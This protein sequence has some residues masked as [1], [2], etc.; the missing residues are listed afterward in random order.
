MFEIFQYDFMLRAFAAGLMIGVLAPAIGVFLVVKRYSLL[1]DTLAHVSLVGVAVSGF[2]GVSPMVGA[3]CAAALGAFG[4]EELRVRKQLFGESVLALMLSGS[5]ALAII[6]F[7]V[8]RGLTLNLLSVLFGSITTVTANDLWAIAL[9]GLVVFLVV[10]LFFKKLFLVSYDEDLARASG[11]PTRWLNAL[12]VVLAAITVS[13][14]I[15]IVGTLL[16]GALMIIPVLAA[17][18]LKFG[19]LK[20]YVCAIALSTLSVISGLFLS[21][22]LGLPS[23]GAIV[24]VAL[25]LFVVSLF[26]PKRSY[27]V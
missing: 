16:I 20:T 7:S 9:L 15:R 10:L 8:S 17:T 21:F 24:L 3:M 19:F 6:L 13:L 18:Q 12:I 26:V 14:S 27:S 4:I 22:Y 23:G 5:L 25:A 1:A 11:L 2:V